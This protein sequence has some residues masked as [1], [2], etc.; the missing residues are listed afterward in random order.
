MK[1]AQD[2]QLDQQ[3]VPKVHLHAS[4]KRALEVLEY[5]DLKKYAAEPEATAGSP[6]QGDHHRPEGTGGV[7]RESQEIG[8]AQPTVAPGAGRMQTGQGEVTGTSGSRG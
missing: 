4:D 6:R 8:G 7:A 3:A 1:A 2:G 5:K